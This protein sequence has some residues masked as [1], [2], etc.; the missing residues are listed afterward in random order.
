M[1]SWVWLGFVAVRDINGLKVRC[2]S[3]SLRTTNKQPE[4]SREELV[5][6]FKAARF[7]SAE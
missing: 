2:Y 1:V 7:G 5:E 6:M 4:G 3:G